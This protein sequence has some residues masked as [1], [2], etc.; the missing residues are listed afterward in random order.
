M[1]PPSFFPLLFYDCVYTCHSIFAGL[2]LRHQH[3][4]P[5]R[6]TWG[7]SHDLSDRSSIS[8][9][10][11][12]IFKSPFGFFSRCVTPSGYRKVQ[13]IWKAALCS[14]SAWKYHCGF[15]SARWVAGC[16]VR[17]SRT[18]ALIPESIASFSRCQPSDR[19]ASASCEMGGRF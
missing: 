13:D 1:V 18:S 4:A 2:F 16:G 10:P 17:L 8:D 7:I 3:T 14:A 19:G 9:A 11:V 6:L 12:A 15:S 5:Y